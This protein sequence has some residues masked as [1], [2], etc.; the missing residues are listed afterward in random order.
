M[1]GTGGLQQVERLRTI[2]SGL[3]FEGKLFQELAQ[4]LA[5]FRTVIDQQYSGRSCARV[6]NAIQVL[7]SWAERVQVH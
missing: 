6:L 3:N 1:G 4:Q 7:P 2:V 5:H